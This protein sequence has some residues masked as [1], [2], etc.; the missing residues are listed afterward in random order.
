MCMCVHVC[1]CVRVYACVYMHRY[2]SNIAGLT[3]D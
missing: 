2:R 1:V 3:A